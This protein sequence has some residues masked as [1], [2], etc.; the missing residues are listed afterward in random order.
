VSTDATGANA[1]P[2]S[3]DAGPLGYLALGLTLLGYGLLQTGVL[4]H[5]QVADAAGLAHLLG[6]VA[7]FIAGLWQLRAGDTLNGTAFA[8]LGAF[9][10][11][12]SMGAGTAA[13]GRNAVGLFLLLWAMLAFTLTAASWQGGL[14]NRAVFG[15]L[16]L[17]LVLNAI[18]VLNSSGGL[19]KAAGWIA[20]VAGLISWYWATA[21]LTNHHWGR[22]A[23]PVK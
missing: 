10:A 9:W 8:G 23:L 7:L 16:T 20:A 13:G 3:L 5:T 4:H 6:G 1:R 11:V 2:A 12:W 15:L 19:V 14:F 21:A 18:G 17:S 22:A